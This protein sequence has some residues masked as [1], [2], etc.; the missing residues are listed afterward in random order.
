MAK[1]KLTIENEEAL[2]T[3]CKIVETSVV[4]S[5][6]IGHITK[7]VINYKRPSDLFEM[8]YRYSQIL[9]APIEKTDSTKQ[10]SPAKEI[11]KGKTK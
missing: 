9:N 1:A 4:E 5:E 7:Y 11:N 8:G 2:L 3:A 10:D 6:K